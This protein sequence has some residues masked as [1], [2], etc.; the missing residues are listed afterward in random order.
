MVPCKT[1]DE[2]EEVAE[3]EEVKN[4]EERR[5]RKRC[6]IYRDEERRMEMEWEWE[7]QKRVL[8]KRE[9]T[10][11]ITVASLDDPLMAPSL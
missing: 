3:V 11:K 2:V 5:M 8:I 6:V 7:K 4:V 1:T 9:L 10:R